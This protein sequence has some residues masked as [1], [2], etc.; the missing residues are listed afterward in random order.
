[1]KRQQEKQQEKQQTDKYVNTEGQPQIGTKDEVESVMESLVMEVCDYYGR[2]YTPKDNGQPSMRATAEYFKLPLL[3]IKKIL[4]TGGLFQTELS[5][6]IQSMYVSGIPMKEI[7]R[8]KNMSISNVSSYLPYRRIIYNLDVRKEEA[9]KALLWRQKRANR[10][11]GRPTLADQELFMAALQEF[12]DVF[13]PKRPEQYLEPHLPIQ[14]FSCTP[15]DG[16]EVLTHLARSRG[17]KV[18]IPSDMTIEEFVASIDGLAL[19]HGIGDSGEDIDAV[20]I[21]PSATMLD[22]SYKK[23]TMLYLIAQIYCRRHEIRGGFFYKRYCEKEGLIG[24]VMKTGYAI[25]SGYITERMVERVLNRTWPDEKNPN[26]TPPEE[27][28][29]SDESDE[30]C[31][32][33]EEYWDIVINASTSAMS[34]ILLNPGKSRKFMRTRRC[35]K[36]HGDDYHIDEDF[37]RQLGISFLIESNEALVRELKKI[38]TRNSA[39]RGALG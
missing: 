34:W 18:S 39:T 23:E 37:I 7:A 4:V 32:N 30:S 27:S 16:P 13:T 36:A 2:T 22:S 38:V 6:E 24:K 15:E 11:I 14:L 12:Q 28:C 5:D 25:W 31:E 26:K 1:M 8:R 17:F 9:I 35:V 10:I 29:E 33:P 19:M 3:K 21:N 20:L